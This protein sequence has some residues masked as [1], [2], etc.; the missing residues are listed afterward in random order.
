MKLNKLNTI[1]KGSKDTMNIVK[2]ELVWVCKHISR[3]GWDVRRV[4]HMYTLFDYS[5]NL[6]HYVK[7]KWKLV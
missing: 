3:T 2:T 7:V 4:V 5:S 6:Y 1:H